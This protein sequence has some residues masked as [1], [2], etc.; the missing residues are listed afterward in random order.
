MY[1]FIV[2][3]WWVSMLEKSP[4]MDRWRSPGFRPGLCDPVAVDDCPFTAGTVLLVLDDASVDTC[5]N[6]FLRLSIVVV[7]RCGG[8]NS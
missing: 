4:L 8:V 1:C 3:F 5:P 7:L 2:R 6:R